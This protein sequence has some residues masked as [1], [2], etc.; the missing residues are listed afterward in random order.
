MQLVGEERK[1]FAQDFY[2]ADVKALDDVAIQS[3]ADKDTQVSLKCCSTS[4]CNS[5]CAYVDIDC[6]ASRSH[7]C[8][9]FGLFE[10]GEGP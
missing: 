6:T 4:A 2:N 7:A 8:N 5:M 10:Q 9:C 1:A 3:G